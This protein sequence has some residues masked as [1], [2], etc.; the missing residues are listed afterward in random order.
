MEGLGCKGDAAKNAVLA[1][2]RGHRQPEMI[3]K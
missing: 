2:P 1:L 3:K